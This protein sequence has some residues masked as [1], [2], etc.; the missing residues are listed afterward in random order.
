MCYFGVVL[1]N[2]T[3]L[4]LPQSLAIA[5]L[6]GIYDSKRKYEYKYEYKREYRT[7]IIAALDKN[8]GIA[9]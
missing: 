1:F 8:L 4:F 5:E 2:V 6:Y 7:P 3:T 9:Y